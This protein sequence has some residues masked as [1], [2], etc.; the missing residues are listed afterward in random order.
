MKNEDQKDIIFSS[1]KITLF[2]LILAIIG[3][4]ILLL[5]IL[6]SWYDYSTLGSVGDTVGGLLNP[7][8][9][10]A[11][12]LLTFLAFYIQYI[13][14]QQVQKQFRIQQFESQFYEMLR[15]H[16]ENV[17]E[18][19]VMGY[20]LVKQISKET[21]S[22]GISKTIETEIQT[23]RFTEDR[24]VFVTMAT[25][26]IA[27]YE[28]LELYNELRDNARYEKKDLLE[29]TYRIFFFG[30]GSGLISSEAI[31]TNFINLIIREL[32][33]ISSE[34]KKSFAKK[35][36][37][38]GH[39]DKS[40]R[41]YVKYKP[42]S[43]HESR[44][45][46]YYRHLYSTVKYVVNQDG[47]LLTYKEVRR[48]LKILRAQ[49]SN[50]EQ[51][52]LYYNYIIGFGRDWEKNGFL[53]KYR[54]LHNLPIDKVRYTEKPRDHFKGYIKNHCTKDDPLFEWGDYT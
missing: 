1:T 12:A 5:P 8:V 16:K 39:K 21:D 43:G 45:G 22:K 30:T 31:D 42:F 40:I 35:N 24:K 3:F 53:T 17:N 29:L 9:G 25:E 50:D 36:K 44:L 15:L 4:L 49:M 52:M 23:V 10:I 37:F 32:K 20:G 14:N 54:M 27:C 47:K 41:L 48:Y 13:A 26:L 18:M 6:S 2:Y 38:L 33:N 34:H 11:A 19:K 7:I 51:L 28:F 46:H